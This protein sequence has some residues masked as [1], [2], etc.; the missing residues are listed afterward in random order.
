MSKTQETLTFQN[1][2][3]DKVHTGKIETK[4][5]GNTGNITYSSSVITYGTADKK[6]SLSI[7]TPEVMI[8][9]T[10]AKVFADAK[11]ESSGPPKTSD[12]EKYVASVSFETD[13]PDEI[14]DSGKTKQQEIDEFVDHHSGFFI[15][16]ER[17]VANFLYENREELSNSK[18]VE[19]EESDFM[20]ICKAKIP[21]YPKRKEAGKT[22]IMKDRPYCK[23]FKTI[24]FRNKSGV[25]VQSPIYLPIRKPSG[26]FETLTMQQVEGLKIYGKAIITVRSI[27]AGNE[28]ATQYRLDSVSVR[29][30]NGI[31]KSEM[32]NL[33]VGTLEREIEKGGDTKALME[34]VNSLKSVS[35][36]PP[37]N[38]IV[39]EDDDETEEAPEQQVD[40]NAAIAKSRKSKEDRKKKRSEE[41]Q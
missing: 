9:F 22:I 31:Q 18:F 10:K 6:H 34:L 2:D 40:L 27:Y 21:N 12:E 41:T 15:E 29:I 16:V 5:V 8:R 33:Q 23:W 7:E 4:Q 20:K 1:F 17:K 37:K 3:I 19:F 36:S 28:I 26:L 24:C 13:T 30:N 32:K 11:D 38:T 39:L 14:T 35:L 25:L